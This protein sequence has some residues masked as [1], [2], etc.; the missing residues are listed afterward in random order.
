[1]SWTNNQSIPFRFGS[2]A[3]WN[4]LTNRRTI[5]AQSPTLGLIKASYERMVGVTANVTNEFEDM[6]TRPLP[7]SMLAARQRKEQWL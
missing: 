5:D 1:M 4:L 6:T 3:L 2:I 7:T